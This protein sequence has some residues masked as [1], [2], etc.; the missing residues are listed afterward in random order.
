MSTIDQKI[1]MDARHS[2]TLLKLQYEQDLEKL[3]THI[4]N[5]TM[6]LWGRCDD[7]GISKEDVAEWLHMKTYD[8]TYHDRGPAAKQVRTKDRI[9]ALLDLCHGDEALLLSEFKRELDKT[10]PIASPSFEWAPR[11]IMVKQRSGRLK[12]SLRYHWQLRKQ[13]DDSDDVAK[14]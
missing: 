4:H 3:R 11:L 13:A 9:V 10:L 12:V 6:N 2:R 14:K 5:D 1:R 7:A 8:E